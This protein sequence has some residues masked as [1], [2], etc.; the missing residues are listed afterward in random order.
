MKYQE[1]MQYLIAYKM[2]RSADLG[3]EVMI[4]LEI[5]MGLTPEDAAQEVADYVSILDP[6]YSARILDMIDITKGELA[7]RMQLAEKCRAFDFALPQ[8][9]LDVFERRTALPYHMIS[10]TTFWC[11][12]PDSIFG[13]P[14]SGCKEVQAEIDRLL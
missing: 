3:R 1:E 4:N 6:P 14:V 12:P 11:Y 7:K 9:W 2:S 5:M 13:I 10:S 8:P